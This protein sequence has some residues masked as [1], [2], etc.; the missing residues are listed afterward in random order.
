MNSRERFIHTMHGDR[1]NRPPLFEEG[2]R[3]EVLEAWHSQ[4]L[5]AEADLKDIFHYEEREEIELDVDPHLNLTELAEDQRGLERLRRSL[6]SDFQERLP[7][8]WLEKLPAWRTRQHPIILE[9]HQG[10]FLSL[11]IED[12]KSFV[13]A[14]Y[15]LADKPDFV[16]QAMMLIG[17]LAARLVEH[18]LSHVA[19]DAALFSEP[20]AGNHGALISPRAYAEFVLP[21][22][23]PIFAALKSQKVDTIILRT[24][25]NARVLLPVIF[26]SK[27]NCLWACETEPNAMEYLA[28]RKEI[29][30]HIRLIGGIDTDVLYLDERDIRQELE[31]VLPPLL[32]QGG[33][34]PLTDGRVRQGVSYKNYAAYRKALEEMVGI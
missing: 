29:N 22:Y 14:M 31:R 19:I 32:E 21:S 2:L 24:Y 7:K 17:E 30:P 8:D 25:A 20:I 13:R 4:G 16:R 28:L 11:G 12:G 26:E 27:F 3:E 15:M 1:S 18:L 23:E 10:F 6:D 5:P 33:Y 34:I 9:V